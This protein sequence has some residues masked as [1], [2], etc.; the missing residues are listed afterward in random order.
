MTYR[1][2]F[3]EAGQGEP[4]ILLHGNGEDHTK[5]EKHMDYW[6]D[7]YH[8]YALD[9]RGHG[10]SP[11][12]QEPFT[13]RQFAE[14][15]KDFFD[16]HEI[17]HAHIIGFSDGA[18]IAM[19]FASKYP[20]YVNKLILAAGNLDHRGLKENF[21]AAVVK[22]YDKARKQAQDDLEQME[23]AEL[24][25]LMIN[26]PNISFEELGQIQAQTLV[27]SGHQDL[28]PVEHSELI[29]DHIEGA[30]LEVQDGD[31][32]FLYD[33]PEAFIDEVDYFL[34]SNLSYEKPEE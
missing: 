17:D 33:N 5:F 25:S 19:V 15:L 8:V 7:Y 29:A 1:H 26:Q 12:G 2:H 3:V 21:Y 11:K 13:I 18:N 22:A 6:Q 14:D 10:Q 20:E 30:F 16:L 34:R 24:L 28:V 31:H 9:T 32:F 23:K 27:I 4:L